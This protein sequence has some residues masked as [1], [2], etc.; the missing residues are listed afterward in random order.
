MT[1]GGSGGKMLLGR[2]HKHEW[3]TATLPDKGRTMEAHWG[4]L[5]TVRGGG[6]GG[7]GE[8]TDPGV[9][10]GGCDWRSGPTAQ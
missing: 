5:P 7:C 3:R 10:G 1:D 2:W 4:R 9:P 8:S 6:G